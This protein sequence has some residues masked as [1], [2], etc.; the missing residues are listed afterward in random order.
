MPSLCA[1]LR[2]GIVMKEYMRKVSQNPVFLLFMQG[3]IAYTALTVVILLTIQIPPEA[4][5]D[6]N[7]KEVIAVFEGD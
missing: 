4:I 6:T 7:L 2:K 1:G 3:T 5:L